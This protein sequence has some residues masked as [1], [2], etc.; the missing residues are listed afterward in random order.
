MG[1]INHIMW[2]IWLFVGCHIASVYNTSING[3]VPAFLLT[4]HVHW[5]LGNAIYSSL[6]N[7]VNTTYIFCQCQTLTETW[8][9]FQPNL[10]KM[11]AISWIG[12]WSEKI[13][14][15]F[16]MCES[17]WQ[18]E[19]AGPVSAKWSTYLPTTNTTVMYET[20]GIWRMDTDSMYICYEQ[21]VKSSRPEENKFIITKH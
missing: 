10:E 15:G 17:S 1:Q 19:Q 7:P 4:L 18:E 6:F 12:L 2:L 13:Q 14:F 11:T 21:R 9:S 8:Y 5:T 20:L 16:I 3:K